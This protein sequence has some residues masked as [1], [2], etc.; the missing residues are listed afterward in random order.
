MDCIRRAAE[1]ALVSAL[2]PGAEELARREAWLARHP[3]AAF[4][5]L[6]FPAWGTALAAAAGW[7]S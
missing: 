5:A 6:T 7:L 1:R 4:A 3:V 2:N